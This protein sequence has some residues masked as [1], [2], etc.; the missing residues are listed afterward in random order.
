[1]LDKLNNKEEKIR[2]RNNFCEHELYK[3]CDAA[4]LPRAGKLDGA[5]VNTE[6]IFCEVAQL[7]DTLNEYPNFKSEQKDIEKCFSQFMLKYRDWPGTTVRDR[8]MIADTVFRIVRELMNHRWQLCYSEELYDAMS[9]VLNEKNELEDSN[10]LDQTLFDN[11]H[12]LDTWINQD[13]N[14]HLCEEI[15]LVA[16]VEP[17]KE[18]KRS[19]RKAV[20]TNSI[21]ASF[22]YLPRVDN[23]PQRLQAFHSG[24]D[25]RFFKVSLR[26]FIDIFTNKSTTKKILWLGD[27]IELKYLINKLVSSNWIKL[28]KS[29][30][31]WQLVCARFNIRIKNH[32][33]ADDRLTNDSSYVELELKESQFNK[34]KKTTKTHEKLDRIIAVLDPKVDYTEAL[35]DYLDYQNSIDDHDELEDTADA[36]EHGLNTDLRV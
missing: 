32:E 5:Q 20:E 4:F 1:M 9:E 12:E 11:S 25:G 29:C 19:G 24:M 17:C 27:I 26:D 13:Y 15:E 6:D 16:K 36:L 18:K 34:S 10:E 2:V 22:D 30:G 3:V 23:R 8:K 21:T 31:K 28:P 35:N 14:G 7:L 33:K